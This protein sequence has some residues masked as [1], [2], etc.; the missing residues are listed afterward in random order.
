MRFGF[1]LF[2]LSSFM[3]H[4]LL[5]YNCT[6]CENRTCPPRPFGCQGN[7]AIDPCGCCEHCAKQMWE[8][9]GG[10]NWELGYCGRHLRCANITGNGLVEIPLAGVC[11]YMDKYPTT[12]YHWEDDD[13]ICPEQSGCYVTTGVCDCVTKRTCISDFR[14]SSQEI[15]NNREDEDFHVKYFKNICFNGGCNIIDERCVCENGHCDRKYQFSDDQKCNAALVKQKCVNV[16]CPNMED[17]KCPKD[18]VATRPYTP[19]GECCATV[20]SFCTCDFETCNNSCP[21]GKR[22]IMVKE[23]D[24]IPGECCDRFLC[25]L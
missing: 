7:Y 6:A 14:F 8:P 22:K 24:G 11:K 18:S 9:C 19:P 20:P 5:A 17:I 2:I 3:V 15:C 25:L 10:E 16:T 21:R 4:G 12:S 23:S 13:E 1:V